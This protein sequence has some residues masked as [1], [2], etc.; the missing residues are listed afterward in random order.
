M[1][2][3]S[4]VIPVYNSEEVISETARQVRDFFLEKGMQYEIILVNDGSSDNSWGVI[5]KLAAAHAEVVAISLLKNY[6]QHNANLCG[7]RKATGDYIITM[8]DDLQNPPNE[9]EKLIDTVGAEYDLV[10][11]RFK[12]KQHSFFRRIGSR[13]VGWINRK[14][15]DVEDSLVLTNFRIIRRDVVDRVCRD[16]SAAPYIP[17]LVLKFSSNRCNVL[18]NHQPRGYGTSNYTLR[19]ILRLVAT[20]LFNHS[21]IPLRFG[22]V[23]GFSVAGVSFFLGLYYL[24]L[25][26]VDIRSTPGWS[27][28]VVLISFFNGI[29]IMLLSIIGEYLVRVLREQ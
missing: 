25:A 4:V 15:F 20:I 19:K 11:G 21:T 27:T 23:F 5:S 10:I 28:L 6:G 3:Y 18:V 17:G 1:K 29:L 22:A 2:K 13:F 24:M 7:F 26:L 12:S 9:I 8:D 14:V 16:H